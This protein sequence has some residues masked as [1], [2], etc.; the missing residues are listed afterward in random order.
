MLSKK[1]FSIAIAPLIAMLPK[2]AV[3]ELKGKFD[4]YYTFFNNIPFKVLQ[5][6][7]IELLNYENIYYAPSI[8]LINKYIKKI[9]YAGYSEDE[10]IDFIK[11]KQSLPDFNFNDKNIEYLLN[12]NLIDLNQSLSKKVV[13]FHQKEIEYK[14]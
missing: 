10:I 14:Q 11:I 6:A 2:P 12:S 1:D 5:M 13:V 8:A 9:I 3:E 7:I 4:I